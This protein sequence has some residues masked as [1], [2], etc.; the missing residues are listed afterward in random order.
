MQSNKRPCMY[1]GTPTK[2]TGRGEHIIPEAIGGARTL[3]DG[4]DKAVC[5]D[6]NSGVLSQLDNEL[7]RRSFL[8]IAASQHMDDAYLWQAWEIDHAANNLILEARPLWDNDKVLVGL[9]CYPQLVFDRESGVQLYGAPEEFY[10]FGPE[11]FAPVLFRAVRRAFKG[12]AGKKR[13]LHLER[14][15]SGLLYEGC[16][17]APHLFAR[18]IDEIARNINEQSFTLRYVNEDDRRFA[19]QC[20]DKLGDGRKLNRG[21]VKPGS[22]TP[23][24]CCYFDVASTLRALMKIGLNLIADQCPNT[25]VNEESFPVVSEDSQRASAAHA[26][27]LRA[28]WLRMR[29]GCSSDKRCGE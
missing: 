12:T 17:L 23:S 29:E 21:R 3:N 8:A 24:L 15:Q 4:S 20:M 6:C 11:H 7:C 14:V 18:R 25:P 9:A 2:K 10:S 28:R 1:C 19:F 13:S 22:H 16:R 26:A 27:R 5:P